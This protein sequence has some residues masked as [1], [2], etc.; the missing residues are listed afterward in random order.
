MADRLAEMEVRAQ[1]DTLAMLNANE[2][3]DTLTKRLA[4][5]DI[6]TLSNILVKLKADELVEMLS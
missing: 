2:L 3:V 4:E 6:N 1:I 5:M